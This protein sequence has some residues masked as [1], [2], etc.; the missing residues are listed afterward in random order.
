MLAGELFP[1]VRPTP[2]TRERFADIWQARKLYQQELLMREVFEDARR[3]V[4]RICQEV[5]QA[6]P[7]A[8][9]APFRVEVF[10]FQIKEH[11]LVD[12]GCHVISSSVL[13]VNFGF[14]LVNDD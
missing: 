13:L 3:F 6:G 11:V 9:S 4:S 14:A 10:L 8:P 7:L 12:S 5:L 1:L 2:F